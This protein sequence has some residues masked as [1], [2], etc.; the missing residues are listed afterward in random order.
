MLTKTTISAI[1]A[2]V[3]LGQSHVQAPTPP[4]RIA[5]LLGESPSYLAKVAGLLVKA[6]ILR[7]H[8]GVAGGVTLNRAPGEISMLDIVEACQGALVEDACQ[9]ASELEKTCAFHQ[10]AVEL[11]QAV[12]G[13]LSRW[14]LADILA[15]PLP[16]PGA[17]NLGTRCLLA[18]LGGVLVCHDSRRKEESGNRRRK[19][20]GK[21]RP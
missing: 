19:R 12:V 7:A 8:R 16:S 6:G 15:K 20:T 5:A 13:V 17:D 14:T 2:L 1:R 21:T 4:R 18:P 11:H 9:Q 3:F 10:A